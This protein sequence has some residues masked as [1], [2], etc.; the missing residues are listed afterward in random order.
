MISACIEDRWILMLASAFSLLYAIVVEAFE[1]NAAWHKPIFSEERTLGTL[2]MSPGDHQCL[3][4]TVLIPHF[5][6]CCFMW[7]V[8][9]KV[10]QYPSC[11]AINSSSVLTPSTFTPSSLQIECS[12]FMCFIYWSYWKIFFL[13]KGMQLLK[14]FEIH[15]PQS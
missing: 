3:N 9:P 4:T 1:E 7:R 12:V 15:S 13:E 14:E 11:G 2:S 5:E 8:P 6:N 10:V